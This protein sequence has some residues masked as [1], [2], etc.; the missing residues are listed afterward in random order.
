MQIEG[1]LPLECAKSTFWSALF[2]SE[3]WHTASEELERFDL[4]EENH[5]EIAVHTEIGPIKGTQIIKLTYSDL[6]PEQ[7]C[8]FL[9]EHNLVK[10]AKGVFELKLPPEVE[11]GEDEE[12]L[13]IPDT[14]KSVLIYYLEVDA[15]NPVFNAILETLKGKLK[16]S[17]EEFLTALALAGREQTA[18]VG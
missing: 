11:P 14:A 6:V 4:V 5:Y 7:S 9:L 2:D 17:F 8:A 1:K 16:E 13:E 10:E 12:P 15:G 3:A 18:E